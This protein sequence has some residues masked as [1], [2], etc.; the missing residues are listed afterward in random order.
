MKSTHLSKN[1]A[2]YRKEWADSAHKSKSYSLLA[3]L[4][5]K[6]AKDNQIESQQHLTNKHSK[7]KERY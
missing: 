4:M 5:M 1:L 3:T 2:S 7:Q 6:I